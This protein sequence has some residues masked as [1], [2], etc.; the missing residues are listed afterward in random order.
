M[1]KRRRRT[2]YGQNIQ[3][4]RI[5]IYCVEK[6]ET[7]PDLGPGSEERRAMAWASEEGTETETVWESV[8]R[9]EAE[10]R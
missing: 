4:G 1:T 6:G 8:V 2:I 10:I 7:E 9:Q 5:L 3:M